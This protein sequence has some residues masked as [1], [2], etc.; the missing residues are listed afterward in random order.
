MENHEAS[1]PAAGPLTASP[2]GSAS[3]P[4][5]RRRRLSPAG[6]SGSA[7]T[8]NDNSVAPMATTDVGVHQQRARSTR[9]QRLS[10][11]LAPVAALLILRDLFFRS[12]TLPSP[13]I[14]AGLEPL[15]PAMALITVLALVMVV[16]LLG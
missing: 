13:H 6:P 11:V 5:A 10:M 7:L 8:L 1:G 2:G 9:L 15:L 14:P 16:P 12:M 3:R 4:R